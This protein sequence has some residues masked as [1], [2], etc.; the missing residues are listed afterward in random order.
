MIM[1]GYF[2]LCTWLEMVW[3]GST[4]WPEMVWN[5]LKCFEIG[6]KGRVGWNK[7]LLFV[8]IRHDHYLK[9]LKRPG[10][11]H[12]FFT[13]KHISRRFCL[14]LPAVILTF[15]CGCGGDSQKA[16]N[17]LFWGFMGG[18]HVFPWNKKLLICIFYLFDLFDVFTWFI[19]YIWCMYLI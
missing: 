2:R 3:N 15:R 4:Q 17:L 7:K 13:K 5:G 10:S 19:W 6:L 12:V 14:K 18:G 1:E 9:F 16:S 11:K 8:K